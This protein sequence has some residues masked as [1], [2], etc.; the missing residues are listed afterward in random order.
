MLLG[1]DRKQVVSFLDDEFFLSLYCSAAS[2]PA[3]C[4]F[5]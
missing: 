3:F 2:A 5:A 4:S 1:Q